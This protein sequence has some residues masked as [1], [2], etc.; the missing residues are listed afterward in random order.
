MK[1]RKTLLYFLI[2]STFLISMMALL[3]SADTSMNNKAK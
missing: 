3:A 1:D 2:L